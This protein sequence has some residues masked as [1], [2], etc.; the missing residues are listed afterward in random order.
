LQKVAI[1]RVI[2]IA[3]KRLPPTIA[4]LGDMMRN[5]GYDDSGK[6]GHFA[7]VAGWGG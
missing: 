2:V 4:P 7:L 5:S 6:A 3:E 1:E